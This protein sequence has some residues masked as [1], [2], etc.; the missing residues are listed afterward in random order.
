MRLGPS[1]RYLTQQ[2]RILINQSY[3]GRGGAKVERE[4]I[5]IS[6]TARVRLLA[7]RGLIWHVITRDDFNFPYSPRVGGSFLI[8]Y[9]SGSLIIST[10]LAAFYRSA[11]IT[12]N[13][14]SAK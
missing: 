8:Y 5:W 14:V 13:R 6:C 12:F 3:L 11:I 7:F 10:V 4:Q 9:S 2:Q 1:V